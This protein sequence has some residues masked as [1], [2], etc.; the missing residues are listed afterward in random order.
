MCVTKDITATKTEVNVCNF[1]VRSICQIMSYVTFST[2][3]VS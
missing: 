1:Q 2:T 3:S